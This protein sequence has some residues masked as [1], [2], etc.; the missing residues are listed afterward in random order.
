MQ[1]IFKLFSLIIMLFIISTVQ[2]ESNF[3]GH[4]SVTASPEIRFFDTGVSNKNGYGAGLN[5]T[6]GLRGKSFG[7]SLLGQLSVGQTDGLKHEFD[8][9]VVT[10]DFLYSSSSAG[11]IFEWFKRADNNNI[12]GIFIGPEYRSID[13]DAKRSSSNIYD[14]LGK[15]FDVDY[16]GYGFRTGVSYDVKSNSKVFDHVSYKLT[17]GYANLKKLD[18]EWSLNGNDFDYKGPSRHKL[19]EQSILFEIGFS[20]SDKIATAGSAVYNKS[21]DIASDIRSSVN[22]KKNN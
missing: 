22:T 9:Q 1:Q 5:T 20:L 2:A 14:G 8:G 15:S 11:I 19:T 10:G 13:F 3:L 21:K 18:A 16:S 12:F 6:L 7:V 17:Y 4:L